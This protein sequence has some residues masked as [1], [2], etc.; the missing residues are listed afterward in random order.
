MLLDFFGPLS[1]HQL[2]SFERSNGIIA[3]GSQNTY[4]RNI[5]EDLQSKFY[6]KRMLGLQNNERRYSFTSSKAFFQE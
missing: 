6:F 3:D 2:D 1:S 4:G 5:A